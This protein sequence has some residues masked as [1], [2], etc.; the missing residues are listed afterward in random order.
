[1]FVHI[2]RYLFKL[3][4]EGDAPFPLL[5]SLPAPGETDDLSMTRISMTIS[6]RYPT[7]TMLVEKTIPD[8]MMGLFGDHSGKQSASGHRTIPLHQHMENKSRLLNY[9]LHWRDLYLVSIG[10]FILSRRCR[11]NASLRSW[12]PSRY[13]VKRLNNW[14]LLVMYILTK[15]WIEMKPV[16]N[17][18]HGKL[19]ICGNMSPLLTV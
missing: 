19:E 3:W 9:L 13:S 16:S 10:R 18:F 6:A 4:H 12:H 11:M 2:T 14:I 1:M 7:I 8:P 15:G 5:L 17:W